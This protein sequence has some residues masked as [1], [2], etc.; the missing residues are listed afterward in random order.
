VDE[1]SSSE[2]IRLRAGH[3][4]ELVTLYENPGKKPVDAMSILYLY[5]AGQESSG[6]RDEPEMADTRLGGA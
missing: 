2:G 3:R 1:V 5:V 6:P 4:Y